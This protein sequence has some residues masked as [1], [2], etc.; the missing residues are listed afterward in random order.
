MA[1]AFTILKCLRYVSSHA[2]KW[3]FSSSHMAGSADVLQML[4]ITTTSSLYH[5]I[6]N[7]L[8][9]IY[10]INTHHSVPNTTQRITHILTTINITIIFIATTSYIPTNGSLFIAKHSI[11]PKTQVHAHNCSRVLFLE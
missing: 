10:S 7:N 5:S 9:I 11:Q 3:R 1:Y 6:H 2:F 8:A 4:P